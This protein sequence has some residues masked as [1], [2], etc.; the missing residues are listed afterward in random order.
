MNKK[1]VFFSAFS[2]TAMAL[3]FKFIAFIKQAVIAYYFG[4]NLETDAYFVA[5]GFINGITE[6]IVK[7][8]SFSIISIYATIVVN[9]GKDHA[10]KTISGILE[11]LTPLFIII[12]AVLCMFSPVIARVLAPTYDND[13][14]S[15]IASFI[16]SLS[17]IML[18]CMLE[19]IF[20]S[21]MDANKD[22]YISRLQSF[23]YSITIIIL[24]ITTSKIL[25]VKTLI[26]GQYISSIVF[27]I[28]LIIAV[29]K[30]YKFSFTSIKNMPEIKTIFITAIPLFIGSGVVQLNQIV[31]KS[32][33]T[34]LSEGSA[35]ALAYSQTL[36]QFVT[37][38]LV[39]N[40]GNV[41]FSHFSDYVAN[42]K[43][44]ELST[45]L[46]KAINIIICLLIPI[47]IITAF[48]SKEIVSI[49]FL[50]GNFDKKAL[51]LTSTVLIGYAISFTF[52]GIRDLIIKSLYSLKNTIYPMIASIVSIICNIALSIYLS[53]KIGII[54]ISIATS[55]SAVLGLIINV[56]AFKH[57]FNIYKFRNNLITTIKNVPSA[58]AIVV[59]VFA[60]NIVCPKIIGFF[61]TTF[62]GGMIYIALLYLFKVD[63]I[64]LFIKKLFKTKVDVNG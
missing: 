4:A 3:F 6:I 62:V 24:C 54:G 25:G 9:K 38:I 5:Y 13:K 1:S 44:E 51:Y 47:S 48:Y 8:I 52:I 63:E 20:G 2:V 23:I 60:I 46:S 29:R 11:L 17:P 57:K 31:D 10:N 30:Y 32:I 18:L 12:T 26:L 34:S 53:R 33:A 28:I 58:I 36:V 49:V 43:M 39:V 59:F 50:R 37:N 19:L 21:I 45:T 7:S 14:V 22:F 42:N 35:S 61:V 64:V 15:L 41:L 56:F 16:Y 40:I 27:S 55:I